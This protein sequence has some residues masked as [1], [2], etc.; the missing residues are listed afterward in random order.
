MS[1]L[2]QA[3]QKAA[4]NR[5]GSGP[6]PGT[7]EAPQL[8]LEPRGA[9]DFATTSAAGYELEASG[10]ATQ[11]KRAVSP[12]AAT[13][14]SAADSSEPT[15]MD[16]V[17]ERPVAAFTLIALIFAVCYGLYLYIQ[18]F[19]PNWLRG[20]FSKPES[21]TAAA[22]P[23]STLP[24]PTPGAQSI[25]PLPSAQYRA[26]ATTPP[27]SGTTPTASSAA[28]NGTLGNGG[29][30]NSELA[31]L[32][33]LP[34]K[35]TA[36]ANTAEQNSRLSK[37]GN[38]LSDSGGAPVAGRPE[39]ERPQKI[40]EAPAAPRTPAPTRPASS[41]SV[42]TPP[43]GTLAGP[44]RLSQATQQPVIE[45]KDQVIV[46]AAPG[47][48]APTGP[49]VSD[50]YRSWKAG[51]LDQ[52]KGIYQDILENDPKNIDAL[53]GVAGIA[54][55]QGNSQEA[56]NYFGRVLESDPRNSSAQAGIIA[57]TGQSD[58]GASETRLKLLISR[59]P[60]GFLHFSLGNLYARQNQWA[61]AQQSYFQA[62]QMD[63][64]NSDYAYNLAVGLEHIGQGKLAITYYRKA[65]DLS[66]KQG[67][68][69]FNQEQ[70]I[71]RIAKLS[72]RSN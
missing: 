22:P 46:N 63:A 54:Q 14:L 58:P 18:L 12:A 36:Q 13:I 2:L 69:T 65:L 6:E 33:N 35:P 4:R 51:K 7:S 67:R 26:P 20:E 48:A 45:L 17:Q 8:E 30:A 34:A 53:L 23:P 70:V 3:L 68:A 19:H 71:D 28:T 10:L 9:G 15:L 39:R 57:M 38:A 52:A 31:S 62:Y 29:Q 24:P 56:L 16:Y 61:Q 59:E 66:L 50:A 72:L 41:P 44:K 49:T 64:D 5:E 32:M 21:I 1:L 47:A 25:L 60:S 40:A 11:T 27:A 43:K 42:T 55:Q 37:L